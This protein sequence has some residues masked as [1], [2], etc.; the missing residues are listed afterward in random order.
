VRRRRGDICQ[1]GAA[2]SLDRHGVSVRGTAQLVRAAVFPHA[3]AGEVRQ[4]AQLFRDRI[5]RAGSAH[6]QLCLAAVC[7]PGIQRLQRNLAQRARDLE[8]ADARVD[9]RADPFAGETETLLF[10]GVSRRL[11]VVHTGG[12]RARR[13]QLARSRF[14][15]PRARLPSS[16]GGAVV[17]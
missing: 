3:L 7:L 16:A 12:P 10:T 6:D 11:V 1:L 14:L 13:V 9:R 8:H 2:T 5:R 4:V 15:Q 17:S